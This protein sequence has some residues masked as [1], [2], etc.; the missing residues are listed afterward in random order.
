MRQKEAEY[1]Q[2][3]EIQ[4]P[5]NFYLSCG[6]GRKGQTPGRVTLSR[7]GIFDSASFVTHGCDVQVAFTL[8]LWK[9][10]WKLASGEEFFL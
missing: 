2:R 1:M 6:N 5:S 3:R 8:K 9:L 4:L 7:G 10:E